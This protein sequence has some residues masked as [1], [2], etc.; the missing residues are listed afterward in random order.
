MQRLH[1]SGCRRCCNRIS[2]N[3]RP[4]CTRCLTQ[5]YSS[6]LSYSVPRWTFSTANILTL[7]WSQTLMVTC[8][9]TTGPLSPTRLRSPH[10]TAAHACCTSASKYAVSLQGSQWFKTMRL[11]PKGTLGL[12]RQRR[13]PW[14]LL[15]IRRLQRP[16]WRRLLQPHMPHCFSAVTRLWASICTSIWGPLKRNSW[17]L[18]TLL[19]VFRV[20][21][22]G[23]ALVSGERSA[24]WIQLSNGSRWISHLFLGTSL[25][26]SISPTKPSHSKTPPSFHRDYRVPGIR[27]HHRVPR[28]THRCFPHQCCGK[29][30]QR[31]L[32]DPWSMSAQPIF[33]SPKICVWRHQLCALPGTTQW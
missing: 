3:I 22:P 32:P 17:Y 7:W 18:M 31:I 21:I 20:A 11:W 13:L 2:L 1:W 19:Q 14:W 10:I 30:G 33:L 12:P 8:T 29:M 23:K 15:Q 25:L 27:C 16:I 4:A 9:S 26:L 5:T 6:C 28:K 24:H